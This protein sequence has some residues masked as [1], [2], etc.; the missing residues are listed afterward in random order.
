MGGGSVQALLHAL[1]REMVLLKL[2]NDDLVC[3]EGPKCS[4]RFDGRSTV[5]FR[6]DGYSGRR[7]RDLVRL[8]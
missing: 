8:K 2:N 5:W 7:L 6:V 4:P 1:D 3:D